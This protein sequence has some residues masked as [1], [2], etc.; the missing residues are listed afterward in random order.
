[1]ISS[2]PG[3]VSS[4]RGIPKEGPPARAVSGSKVSRFVGL[5]HAAG[6]EGVA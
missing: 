1:M 2:F 4:Q 5:G 3:T 6:I